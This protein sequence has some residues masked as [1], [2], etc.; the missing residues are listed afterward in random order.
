MV[1]SV[2]FFVSN[3]VSHVIIGE[4][5]SASLLKQVREK[6]SKS[7]RDVFET[8]VNL[9]G[10]GRFRFIVFRCFRMKVTFILAVTARNVRLFF[11]SFLVH[12]CQIFGVVVVGMLRK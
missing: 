11:L 7:H 9:F 2:R 5:A 1:V 4:A 8:F 3:N 12:P 10:D 6:C